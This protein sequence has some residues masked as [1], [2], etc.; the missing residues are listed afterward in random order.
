[1][2]HNV[3]MKFSENILLYTLTPLIILFIGASYMRF[4]IIHDYMV[5]Y[6][7]VCDPATNHCFIGCEDEQCTTEYYYSK[8]QKYAPNI[9][10]QCGSNITD[11]DNA[12]ICTDSETKCSITFCEAELD[13]EICESLDENDLPDLIEELTSENRSEDTVLYSDNILQ[14]QKE[15]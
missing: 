11:C 2:E 12:S 10:E 6:E 3:Y 13:G 4:F 1:M 7:G 15:F 14:E 8:I 9:I 5:E